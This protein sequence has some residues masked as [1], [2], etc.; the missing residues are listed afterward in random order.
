MQQV[1]CQAVIM[2]AGCLRARSTVLMFTG[3]QSTGISD[4]ER[5]KG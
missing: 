2:V 1:C 4:L 5:C 3:P